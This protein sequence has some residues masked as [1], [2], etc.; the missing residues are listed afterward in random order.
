MPFNKNN[1]SQEI[2][3]DSK[4]KYSVKSAIYSKTYKPRPNTQ[5]SYIMIILKKNR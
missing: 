2:D 1:H 4:S 5:A 3:D